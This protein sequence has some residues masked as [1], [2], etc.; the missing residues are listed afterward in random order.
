MSEDDCFI[1]RLPVVV[2]LHPIL[3]L[4]EGFVPFALNRFL[5]QSFLSAT[6]FGDWLER[7]VCLPPIHPVFPSLALCHLPSLPSSA[8]RH[9]T[10]S[11]HSRHVSASH[12]EASR[13]RRASR[14]AH[15]RALDACLAHQP[16]IDTAKLRALSMRGFEDAARRRIAWPLLLGVD[17]AQMDSQ[18]DRVRAAA[19]TA[20]RPAQANETSSNVTIAAPSPPPAPYDYYTGVIYQH[21]Y[22]DQIEKDINRSMFHFDCTRVLREKT[23]GVSRQALARIIHT[24]FSRHAE[25]HYIQGFHDIASVFLL[26]CHDA[27]DPSHPFDR[28]SNA[29]GEELA[30][31]LTER[32]A[33]LHIRDSLRPSLDTV[34]EVL[35][36]IFPLLRVADPEVHDFLVRTNVQSF[37]TLSWILTW[38]SHN[39]ERFDDICRVFDFFLSSHPLMPL[40]STVALIVQLRE[41]LLNLRPAAVRANRIQMDLSQTA[42]IGSLP[43]DAE[44]E[45]DLSAVHEYFQRLPPLLD[46]DDLFRRTASLYERFPPLPLILKGRLKIPLDSPLLAA[47][48]VQTGLAKKLGNYLD[49]NSS[50]R[51]QQ[52]KAGTWGAAVEKTRR[53]AK[54]A[55]ELTRSFYSY[56]DATSERGVGGKRKMIVLAMIVFCVVAGAFLVL[57]RGPVPTEAA[58]Q[59][60]I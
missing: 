48:D 38:F 27:T 59:A 10:K 3:T 21:K 51:E 44:V 37:F 45:V 20:A 47:G 34:V 15:I 2:P 35:S 29:R 33:L 7:S 14:G 17:V 43:E 12:V 60:A 36:L 52:M 22:Y 4:L 26:V 13:L 58:A 18:A 25:L 40:Y 32:L 1:H 19:S 30:F 24:V 50:Q 9:R 54:T 41:G 6:R 53:G 49:W 55:V 28:S 57:Q 42:P 31:R 8:M 16:D 5:L 23:R 39:L 11:S 46:L 56:P